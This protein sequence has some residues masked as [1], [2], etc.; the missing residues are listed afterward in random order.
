MVL[1]G[2]S[3]TPWQVWRGTP[4]FPSL[5]APL[6]QN[7]VSAPGMVHTANTWCTMCDM[8]E[9]YESWKYDEHYSKQETAEVPIEMAR[10]IRHLTSASFLDER[11]PVAATSGWFS[12]SSTSTTPSAI[13][14]TMNKVFFL[15]NYAINAY[16]IV[17]LGSIIDITHIYGS[18]LFSTE[19]SFEVQWHPCY[20]LFSY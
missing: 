4:P 1:T 16:V 6:T 10:V 9:R 2:L 3:Q 5:Y 15:D 19:S 12:F 11:L 8:Q 13:T 7:P 14:K 18:I 20:Y 17:D